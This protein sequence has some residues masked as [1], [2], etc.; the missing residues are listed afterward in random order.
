MESGKKFLAGTQGS[1]EAMPSGL[2]G[3]ML[4]GN[5]RELPSELGCGDLPLLESVPW[6]REQWGPRYILF[7]HP[8]ALWFSKC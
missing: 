6:G 4:G 2:R 3:R 7:L 5:K 1:R 8:G